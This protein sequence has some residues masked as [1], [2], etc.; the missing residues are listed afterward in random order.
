[1]LLALAM[2]SCMRCSLVR[3]PALQ[4]EGADVGVPKLPR[5][6]GGI[7][8]SARLLYA[9]AEVQFGKAHAYGHECVIGEARRR[10]VPIALGDD[11][12]HGLE[13]LPEGR[14]V[15]IPDTDPSVAILP[16][17]VLGAFLAWFEM[18]AGPHGAECP[19]PC[20]VLAH[21]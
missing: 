16:K 11:Q 20:R 4:L 21:A 1:M 5:L 8:L 14:I 10:G 19:A 15:A 6:S 17:Q 13:P 18:Q 7:P 2:A 9:L 3:D 12:L